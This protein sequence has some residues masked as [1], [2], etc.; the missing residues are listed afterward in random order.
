M[1]VPRPPLG[2]LR[3][4]LVAALLLVA[5]HGALVARAADPILPGYLAIYL[6]GAAAPLL[7]VLVLLA[8]KKRELALG[9]AVAFGAAFFVRVLVVEVASPGIL[10]DSASP[11]SYGALAARV[12]H[13]GLAPVLLLLVEAALR[14]HRQLAPAERSAGAWR[15]GLGSGL[16]AM[17]L[18]SMAPWWLLVDHTRERAMRGSEAAAQES[19]AQIGRCAAVYAGARP[20]LGFPTTLAALGPDG[21]RC[22]DA[23]TTAGTVAGY[24][25]TLTAGVG[26]AAGAVHVYVACAQ[27]IDTRESSVF[28]YVADE[29][30]ATARGVP[31]DVA[32][33]EA[34]TPLGCAA[35][36]FYDN[37][38]ERG[39]KHCVLEW[40]AAHPE[41][42]YPPSLGAVGPDG[43]GCLELFNAPILSGSGDAL[44]GF[45]RGFEYRAATP[46]AHGVVRDFTLR[47]KPPVPAAN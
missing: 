47:A 29:G 34:G 40:A 36:W 18:W 21:A 41:A 13:A 16:V 38:V 2:S 1:S 17:W 31:G 44:A 3:V 25:L 20:D 27:P 35:T 24:R 28:T 22:L 9:C 45:E 14:S 39:I 42:G 43:T 5:G 46:D 10:G 33:I 12:V 15:I 37:Q 23:G 30:S 4:Y 26:D 6:T 8:T 32:A 19:L 7:C 11:T